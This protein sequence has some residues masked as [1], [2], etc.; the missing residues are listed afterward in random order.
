MKIP[1]QVLNLP[2]SIAKV[3]GCGSLINLEGK[4]LKKKCC[5]SYKKGKACK[6][7]PKHKRSAI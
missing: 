3:V 6:K 5:K 4:N 1:L 7:C 2:R